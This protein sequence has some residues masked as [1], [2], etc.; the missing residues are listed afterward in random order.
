M[1]RYLCTM[2]ALLM[3]LTA[4]AAPATSEP[5]STKYIHAPYVST[6]TAEECFICSES[7][8]TSTGLY[9]GEDNVGL[10]N[11]NT[12]EVLRI[13]INRYENGKLVEKQA[14]FMRTTGMK[15]GSV[16]ATTDPDR[17]YSHVRIGG[18]NSSIDAG[19]IQSHLC[20]TCLD[21]INNMH[22]GDYPPEAYAIVNFTDKTIRP[23][24]QNTT[25]FGSGNYGVDCEFED[26]GNI[27]LLIFYCPPRYQ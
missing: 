1:K 11:L 18:A 26:D 14:G 25:F 23:L 20:Q 7:K 8:G 10:L 4:C 27:D 3:V 22:F 21:E 16:F 5:E 6:I 9:W 24:I 2:I 19:S 17:G 15:S 12:F 13:E